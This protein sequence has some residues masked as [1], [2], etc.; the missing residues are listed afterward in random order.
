VVGSFESGLDGGFLFFCSGDDGAGRSLIH[1]PV[2]TQGEEVPGGPLIP[3]EN[4]VLLPTDAVEIGVFHLPLFEKFRPLSRE[5]DEDLAVIKGGVLS[6]QV[7]CVG[8]SHR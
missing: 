4:K 7:F 8:G 6:E 5:G 3:G 2:A 1:I